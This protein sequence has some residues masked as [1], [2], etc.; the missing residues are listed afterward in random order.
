MWVGGDR[1]EVRLLRPHC[2]LGLTLRVMGAGR[3]HLIQGGGDQVEG[4]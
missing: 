1:L 4:A 3:G 2:S